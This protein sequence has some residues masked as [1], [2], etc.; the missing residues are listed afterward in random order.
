MQKHGLQCIMKSDNICMSNC[1][2]AF[3]N[4]DALHLIAYIITLNSRWRRCIS[5]YTT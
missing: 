4:E 3:C 5:K 1:S 2:C